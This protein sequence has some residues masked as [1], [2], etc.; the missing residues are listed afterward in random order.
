MR[1]TTPLEGN[2]WPHDMGISVEDDSAP[3]LELLW[4]REA[5]GLKPTG[6]RLPPGLV[7]P[8]AR[9]GDPADHD[10][11]EAAWPRMWEDAVVHT[12]VAFEP[13][14]FE[15]PA[16]AASALAERA[17]LIRRVHGPTW[18]ERFGDAALGEGFRAWTEA[19]FLTR[20]DDR[21]RSL[22]ESPERRSLDA[23][24]AAWRIGLSN[25]VTIPCRGDHTRVIGGSVLLVTEATRKDPERYD[26]ALR[27]FAQ[28]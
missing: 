17:E 27:T 9:A 4:L 19:R 6:D 25:V 3:L 1:S 26:A 15:V 23:L 13:S 16:R 8:P 11:W 24:I 7:D 5:W 12:A 28:R 21:P 14:L 20:R 22:A 18:R 10:A 2:P